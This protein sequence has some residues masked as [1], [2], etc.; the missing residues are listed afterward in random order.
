MQKFMCFILA[1]MVFGFT[2]PGLANGPH[3]TGVS[4]KGGD[5]TIMPIGPP[6][7]DPVFFGECQSCFGNSRHDPMDNPFVAPILGVDGTI[8]IP[9]VWQP[10]IGWIKGPWRLILQD[11]TWHLYDM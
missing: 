10:G 3:L 1:I 11:G 5:H 2:V 8:T 6:W 7:F 9:L 4:S